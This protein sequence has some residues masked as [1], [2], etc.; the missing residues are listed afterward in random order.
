MKNCFQCQVL[1]L[2]DV[3]ED[4]IIRL[5]HVNKVIELIGTESVN[6]PAKQIRQV[7]FFCYNYGHR[8]PLTLAILQI[9][10]MMTKEEMLDVELKIEQIL[11]H[12]E[13][14]EHETAEEQVL[15]ETDIKHPESGESDEGH[16]EE[17]LQKHQK[18]GGKPSN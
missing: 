8:Q 12:G 15:T 17:Q 9:I 3:D 2:M 5:E 14:T 16:E 18:N 1:S 10:D 13:S 6:I 7:E 11:K 4:G